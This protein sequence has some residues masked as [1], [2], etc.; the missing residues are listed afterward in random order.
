MFRTI[1]PRAAVLLTIVL[2][3]AC[4]GSTPNPAGP[5]GSPPSGTG[6]TIQGTVSVGTGAS[7]AAIAPFDASG[8]VTVSVAGT[9]LS[10]VTDSQGRFTLGV[11]TGS[12]DLLFAS[13]AGQAKLT[14]PN[15]QAAEQITLTVALK[16]TMASVEHEQRNGAGK[17]EL[18]GLISSIETG[19]TQS[20]TV[21]ATTV[22]VTET[23]TIRHGNT[24]VP[25]ASLAVGDRVHVKGTP[26]TGV[27]VAEMVMLQN[28]AA[29]V[30][31]PTESVTQ[32]EG[33]VNAV[34]PGG[35]SRTLLVDDTTV[36][37]PA[38][39][40]IRHGGTVV[41]FSTI[42][43]GDRVH[44]K[45][46]FSGT[47]LVAAEVMV[48]NTNAKVPVNAKGT[49]SRV[50]TGYACPSIRF[51]VEGWLVETDTSTSF[52]KGTCSAVVVGATVHVKGEVQS[53]GRVLASW[54]QIGK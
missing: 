28:P 38:A 1:G 44:V 14:V 16:G 19:A 10:T 27:V 13:A 35:A 8:G 6:A 30:P 42:K 54:V 36:S 29:T 17:V 51:T 4:G 26:G 41:E 33:R 12:V 40:T 20:F 43:V 15:V 9:N 23:T 18:E 37:V 32:L 5:S 7:G 22:S 50:E 11:P 48:Q 25:F 53:T 52:E 39:A 24:P 47:T 21:S 49:V 2:F 45:G 34:N 46:S 3:A 31:P